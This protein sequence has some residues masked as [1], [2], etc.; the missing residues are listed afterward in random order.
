MRIQNTGP[1]YDKNSITKKPTGK[2]WI[3]QD[4][5]A[6]DSELSLLCNPNYTLKGASKNPLFKATPEKFNQNKILGYRMLES[7]SLTLSL[8]FC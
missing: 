4:A 3:K 8:Q 2:D 7:W 5:S 6:L 1:I